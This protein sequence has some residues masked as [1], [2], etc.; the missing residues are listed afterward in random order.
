MEQDYNQIKQEYDAFA[1]K[2]LVWLSYGVPV[3]L[4]LV[5]IPMILGLIPPNAVYG[6]RTQY[7][8]S[9]PDIWYAENYKAGVA[10]AV[11]SL[12]AI[13]VIYLIMKF[14]MR[15]LLHKALLGLG[16]Y[17]VLIIGVASN[18]GP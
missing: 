2:I 12:V 16:I 14:S 3:I 8:I 7:T 5:S 4:L 1:M 10:F 6:Y 15:P 9:S 11:I 17:T 13:A 18:L